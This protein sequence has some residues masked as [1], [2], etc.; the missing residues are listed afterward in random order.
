MDLITLALAQ[1]FAQATPGTAAAYA[2]AAQE[3]ATDAANS[4]AS[5]TPS[6]ADDVAYITGGAVTN[7]YAP[8]TDVIS[9]TAVSIAAVENHRYV[10]SD[11]V[12][13]LSITPAANGVTD[14]LFASGST[15]TVLTL[16]NTVVLP[17]WF[18]AT[19]LETNTVYEISILDGVYCT[20]ATW[21]D[22]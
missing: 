8:A 5:V 22:S 11:E 9:G 6:N 15:P 16:P 21:T 14:V 7:T 1:A 13:T 12:L 18:D 19:A 4:A 20:V 17:T 3:S 10:C 2:A